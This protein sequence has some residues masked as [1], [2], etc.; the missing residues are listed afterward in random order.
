MIR[1]ALI[2]LALG[3]S[4]EL[5]AAPDAAA[6]TGLS[7]SSKRS[8][9]PVLIRNEHNPVLR[10]IVEV[11][12]APDVRVSAFSF[13]LEGTDDLAYIE[14]LSLFATGDQEAFQITRPIAEPV[15]PGATITFRAALTL[16]ADKNVF[17]LSCRLKNSADLSHRIA[18]ACCAVE[19][20]DGRLIPT[21]SVPGGRQRIGF[22]LRKHHDDGVP[23]HRIPALATTP[24]E[25]LLCAYDRRATSRDLQGN[26]DIGLSRSTDAGRTWEPGR[27]IMDMG[28]YGGLPQDQN[29]C[30]DPG[31]IV[32]QKTG[33]IFCFAVWMN[34]KPG[35]HQW[36]DDGSEPGFEIGKSAQ[37][38][39]VRS[40]DDGLTWS[41]P[42]KPGAQAQTRGLVAARIFAAARDQSAGRHSGDSNRRS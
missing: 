10:M 14:A 27:V 22:A 24:K 32:D 5:V 17:W 26:I 29:G 13:R 36:T 33:E 18:A 25:T 21:L 31:L 34:G 4:N 37:L 35:K 11:P 3:Q 16:K 9:H 12:V 7:A 1:I 19:T 23:I 41:K 42:E 40:T 15:P 2:I 8:I 30:S 39:M 20:T 38:I 28:E 6:P